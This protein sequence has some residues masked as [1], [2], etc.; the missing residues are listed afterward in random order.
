MT[1]EDNAWGGTISNIISHTN[2]IN[3]FRYFLIILL[4]EVIKNN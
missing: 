2:G 4:L 1:L 3:R